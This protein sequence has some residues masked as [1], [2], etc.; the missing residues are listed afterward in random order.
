MTTDAD[1]A[2]DSP[3]PPCP[4][5]ATI[6]GVI[7]DMDGVLV[8]SEPFTAEAAI[9][10]FA[11]KGYTVERQEFR[12]FLGTGEARFMGGVAEARGIP[13]DPVADV[14]HL[15][16]IYL[17]LI[18]GRLGPLKGAR[19]FALACRE[20]GLLLAVASS[21]NRIKVE[22]NLA[23]VGLPEG[24]FHAVVT[25]CE[26]ARKK[27]APDIFLEA[28]RRL[29]LDPAACLV[30]EDAPAGIA[31]AREAGCRCL[32]LTTTMP[33]ASFPDADWIAPDLDHVPPE[34]TGW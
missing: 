23:E 2:V 22:G 19:A 26:V 33:A 7:F 13:F 1:A 32:A 17:N 34:A 18:P 28:A 29:G 24:T 15:Y 12:P 9:R 4:T 27:P 10:V 8:A 6:R 5:A 16:R 14:D 3:S 21:A 20:R 11:E 30:V 25:G 31:A